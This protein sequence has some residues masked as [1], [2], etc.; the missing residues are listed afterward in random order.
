MPRKSSIEAILLVPQVLIGCLMLLARYA[1]PGPVSCKH[2]SMQP[3]VPLLK[4]R[5]AMAATGDHLE[6]RVQVARDEQQKALQGPQMLMP[7]A[8]EGLLRLVSLTGNHLLNQAGR[9]HRR[10]FQYTGYARA[11]RTLD[12][13]RATRMGRSAPEWVTPVMQREPRL[14][15]QGLRRPEGTYYRHLLIT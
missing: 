7:R 13:S 2:A 9:P 11:L 4:Q 14:Y 6:M 1:L 5:D 8:S 10:R 12:H 15:T 3:T